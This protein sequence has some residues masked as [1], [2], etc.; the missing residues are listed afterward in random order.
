MMK[1][2]HHGRKVALLLEN[3]RI[4]IHQLKQ[5]IRIY[6]VEVPCQCKVARRNGMPLD[7]G[8]A[9]FNIVLALGT[10]AQ[11]PQQHLT[12]KR[13]VTFHQAG[14]VTKIWIEFLELVELITN[15]LENVGNGLHLP[16]PDP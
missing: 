6:K 5:F 14:M 8:M 11:M 2:F 10:I 16:T 7:K 15:L 4:D 13:K 12:Q 1:H 9:E 3:T